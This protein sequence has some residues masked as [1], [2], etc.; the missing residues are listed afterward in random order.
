MAAKSPPSPP[1]R[2]GRPRAAPYSS[3]TVHMPAAMHDRIIAA[4]RA[5]DESVSSVVRRRL[6]RA[7]AVLQR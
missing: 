2:P 1:R 3:L 6:Q 4:A 5:R 7:L